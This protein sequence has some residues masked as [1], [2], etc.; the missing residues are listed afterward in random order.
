[1]STHISFI[2][3]YYQ[4]ANKE[5]LLAR[6]FKVLIV[7]NP[8]HLILAGTTSLWIPLALKVES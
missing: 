6:V 2:R 5:N 8:A 7:Q 4:G 3:Y 1:M